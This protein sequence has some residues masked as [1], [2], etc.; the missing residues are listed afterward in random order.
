MCSDET[1]PPE[2]THEVFGEVISSYTRAD[3]IRDGFL[4]DVSKP[5]KEAGWVFPVAVTARVW[6]RCVEV[7]PGVSGQDEIGRLWDI[8]WMSRQETVRKSA[9]AD[10]MHFQ[11]HVRNDNR[12]GMPPLVNLKAVCGPGDHAEPVVCIMFPDED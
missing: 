9:A 8:L 1:R 7:A 10:T 2:S 3:A 11:L 5:A 12:L 6:A 4:I